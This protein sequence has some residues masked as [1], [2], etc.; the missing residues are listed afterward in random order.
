MLKGLVMNNQLLI[1]HGKCSIKKWTTINNLSKKNYQQ[2]E[3]QTGKKS[4][5]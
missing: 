3:L 2:C 1:Q 4:S 5:S